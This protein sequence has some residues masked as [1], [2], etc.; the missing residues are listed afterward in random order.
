MKLA[1]RAFLSRGKGPLSR[2]TPRTKPDGSIRLS[3]AIPAGTD[4]NMMAAVALPGPHVGRRKQHPR[5]VRRRRR[6]VPYS[7]PDNFGNFQAQTDVPSIRQ[8]NEFCGGPH[9]FADKFHWDLSWVASVCVMKL[10]MSVTQ[11]NETR[12]DRSQEAIG[13]EPPRCHLENE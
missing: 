12:E 9:I 10:L 1:G 13:S 4:E 11:R 7:K 6:N 2:I 8:I 3:K 5:R